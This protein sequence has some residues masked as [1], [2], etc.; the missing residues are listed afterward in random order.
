MP[1]DLR[2]FRRFAFHYFRYYFSPFYFRFHWYWWLRF[3]HYAID[4]GFILIS[5]R[6]YYDCSRWYYAFFRHAMP[7]LLMLSFSPAAIDAIVILRQLTLIAI[8]GWYR[9]FRWCLLPPS[10]LDITPPL[11]FSFHWLL[12]LFAIAS[13]HYAAA[14]AMPLRYLPCCCHILPLILRHWLHFLSLI[15]ISL[16]ALFSLIIDITFSLRHIIFFHTYWL[17]IFSL[18][19][20]IIFAFM[21]FSPLF[22]YW[23]CLYWLFQLLFHY[24][25][26]SIAIFISFSLMFSPLITVT[27]FRMPLLLFSLIIAIT[28]YY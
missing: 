14:F 6:H 15:I 1:A 20:A 9:H 25:L 27:Y 28:P 5:R 4:Y 11:M 21:P 18:D 19:I 23:Y 22:H 12:M 24:S 2:C 3:R 16:Y 17:L 26:A 13:R 8:A 7:L 10:F